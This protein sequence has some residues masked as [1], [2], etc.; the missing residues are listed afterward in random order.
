MYRSIYKI[1]LS[2]VNTGFDNGKDIF[3]IEWIS[4]L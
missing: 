3:S 1:N 2:Q 4:Q